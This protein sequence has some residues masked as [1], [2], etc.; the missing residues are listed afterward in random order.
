MFQSLRGELSVRFESIS[1]E[2]IKYKY[3]YSKL[4]SQNNE[5]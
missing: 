3:A 2:I 5:H 4:I 1:N